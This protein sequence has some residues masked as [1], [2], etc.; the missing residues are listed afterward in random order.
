[1]EVDVK[2]SAQ[3]LRPEAGPSKRGTETIL[4]VEDDIGVRHLAVR[5]LVS[6]GYHVLEAANGPE[7]LQVSEGYERPI[8][9]L[10]TDVVMPKM[11]GRELADR[12]RGQRPGMPVLYMSGYAD[13]AISQIG[14]LPAGTAFLP[15]PFS[16]EE[17]IRKVRVLM[18]ELG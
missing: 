13:N 11:N 7:A 1:M 17:L 6:Y 9:L 2:T 3:F 8:H 4:V 16:V 18:P 10:L 15:K 5:V 14:T 12:L